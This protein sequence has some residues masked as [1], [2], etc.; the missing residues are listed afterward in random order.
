M[1]IMQSIATTGLIKKADV[2]K[3]N[4][5]FYGCSGV[6]LAKMECDKM[7]F[8]RPKDTRIILLLDLNLWFG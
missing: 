3:R 4:M 7:H 5:H 6:T 2:L 1:E 8:R